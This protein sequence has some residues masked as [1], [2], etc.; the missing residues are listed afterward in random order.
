MADILLF[1]THLGKE[2]V[3][4]KK[5]RLKTKTGFTLIELMIVVT[6]VAILAAMALPRFM[7]TSA[8]TKQKEAQLLLK[9]I[10]TMERA[11]RQEYDTYYPGNG[12][13]V[14]V[15]PGGIVTRL[16]VEIMPSAL[17]SY[18]VTSDRTSFSAA[19]GSK[20]AFGLDDDATLDVWSI[21]QTGVLTCVTDDVLN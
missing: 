8:K 6:I 18:A 20:S 15:Q 10:Y 19:A 1:L 12:G 14:V 5:N 9:Q 3:T 17:Y 7:R 2:E 16:G 13:T 11:Y 4:L 21:D